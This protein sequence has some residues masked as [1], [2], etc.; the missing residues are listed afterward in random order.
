[1]K[2]L[3]L[4]KSQDTILLEDSIESKKVQTL[5]STLNNL[6]RDMSNQISSFEEFAASQ[7]NGSY[8]DKIIVA[9]SLA[10]FFEGNK[11]LKVDLAVQGLENEEKAKINEYYSTKTKLL[12]TIR[13]LITL[14]N[15]EAVVSNYDLYEGQFVKCE[16]GHEIII[17]NGRNTGILETLVTELDQDLIVNGNFAL[18][19]AQPV[20]FNQ[21]TLNRNI[22]LCQ[23]KNNEIYGSK[24][25]K[26]NKITT[27][28]ERLQE[29]GKKVVA[30]YSYKESLELIG[31]T[32]KGIKDYENELTK[33][34]I[35]LK[36]TLQKELRIELED[37][38]SVNVNEAEYQEVNLDDNATEFSSPLANS[39]FTSNDNS[40]ATE[41]SLVSENTLASE[42]IDAVVDAVVAETSYEDVT[43]VQDPFETIS[44][45]PSPFDIMANE[46]SP[47]ENV[48]KEPSPFENVEN[49]PSPFDTVSNDNP[50][51]QETYNSPFEDMLR[52]SPFEGSN[53]TT[54]VNNNSNNPFDDLN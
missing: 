15:K 53:N 50:F 25:G 20:D 8:N 11:T 27:L 45:E 54:E 6:I 41:E 38:C 48:A 26:M 31:C 3:E 49:E 52:R 32:P 28:I 39:E 21:D 1:M 16:P 29:V 2:A 13:T 17:L 22:E 4:L 9:K 42:D 12:D 44:S 7:L 33:S 23:R 43:P 40:F 34:Y 36:K 24:T 5:A 46:P 37:I 30:F 18:V 10:R 51:E 14:S 47:F 19:D 35:P